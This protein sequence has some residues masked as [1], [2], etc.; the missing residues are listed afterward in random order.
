[1]RSV[2]LATLVLAVMA[3]CPANRQPADSHEPPQARDGNSD[4]MQTPPTGRGSVSSNFSKAYSVVREHAAKIYGVSAGKVRV[5]PDKEEIANLPHNAGVGRLWAFDAQAPERPR[6]GAIHV[7]ATREGV[8]VTHEQNL[9]IL[10]EEAGVW[11]NSPALNAD[12]LAK[13]IVGSM[14]M[15]H[16]VYPFDV[17]PPELTLDAS[18]A[19]A[20]VFHVGRKGIGPGGSGGGPEFQAEAKVV[21]TPDHQAK[22]ELGPWHNP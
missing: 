10:F 4:G 6:L 12:E 11:T 5:L 22:L 13:L 16:R 9:G 19:G 15:E 17:P 1:M 7:F 21:L 8:L 2:L 3:G 14:G 20:L 18:G